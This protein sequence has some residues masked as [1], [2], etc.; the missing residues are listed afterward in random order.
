M[1]DR[2][3]NLA[4]GQDSPATTAFVIAPSDTADLQEVTRAL[5]VGTGTVAVITADG[6]NVLLPDM[7]GTWQWDL[8]VSRVLTTGTTATVLVGL[9]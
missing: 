2:F 7:G 9:V 6:A 3:R 1:T 5:V 4:A 8:R